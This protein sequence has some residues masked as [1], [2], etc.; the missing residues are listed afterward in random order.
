MQKNRSRPGADGPAAGP[1]S[2]LRANCHYLLGDLE[3]EKVETIV[4]EIASYRL[5][6]AQSSRTADAK[7]SLTVCECVGGGGGGM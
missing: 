3:Q 7:C 6:Y 2:P 4:K 1:G 5:L